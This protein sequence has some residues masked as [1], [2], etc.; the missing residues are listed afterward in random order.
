MQINNI[1]SLLNKGRS[2]E[3][4]NE[5]VSALADKPGN[6]RLRQLLGLTLARLGL[7]ERAKIVMEEL[8]EEESD[9]ETSGILGGYTKTTGN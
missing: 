9:P 2:F 7:L 5:L 6:I 1:E 3:A 4:Y 8:A